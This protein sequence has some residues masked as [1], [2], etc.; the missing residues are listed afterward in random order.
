MHDRC[1]VCG[2]SLPV[3]DLGHDDH[4]HTAT[5][6]ASSGPGGSRPSLFASAAV[7]LFVV[8]AIVALLSRDNSEPDP[9]SEP[10]PSAS[11]DDFVDTPGADD[12]L[13]RSDPLGEVVAPTASELTELLQQHR[14]AYLTTGAVIVIDPRAALPVLEVPTRIGGSNS[15][16]AATDGYELLHDGGRTIG[17][18]LRP[19]EA[20]VLSTSGRLVPDGKGGFA[21]V[22]DPD[23]VVR[24]LLITGTAL[25]LS[26]ID[27][28]AGS[29]LLPVDNFGVIVTSAAGTSYL[30]K[31]GRLE[32][33]SDG[34]IVAATPTHH[35]EVRC[36]EPLD[37]V[38]LLVDRETGEAVELPSDF[39]H[40]GRDISLSPNG[41]WLLS[42]DP[43]TTEPPRLYETETQNVTQLTVAIPIDLAWSPDGAVAAWFQPGDTEPLLQIFD[44]AT[45]SVYAFDLGAI[46]APARTADSLAI[47]R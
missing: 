34:L 14:F 11:V 2:Q 21:A 23:G 35:V 6:P 18:T 28:P 7:A 32:Q 45:Q 46:G 13:S 31:P 44:P 38:N 26:G 12:T 4:T 39:T 41:R 5:T 19:S 15:Y 27:L 1:T 43:Q 42:D 16:F 8:I 17:L 22:A 10:D 33:L 40:Y 25:L 29:T 24:K 37:C 36:A 9:V 3:L 20:V 30:A 47:I